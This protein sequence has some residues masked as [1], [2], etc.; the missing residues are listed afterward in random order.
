MTEQRVDME[1]VSFDPPAGSSFSAFD[2]A[3][4]GDGPAVAPALWG[5]FYG[6]AVNTLAGEPGLGKSWIAVA[7]SLH[8]LRRGGSVIVLDYEDSARTWAQRL[9]SLGAEQEQLMDL[10][11]FRGAGAPAEADLDWLPRLAGAAPDVLVVIDSL[12]EALAAA[13]LDENLAGDV[14]SWHQRIARPLADA[15]ATVLLIDHLAKD[16]S[17]RGRWARGSGAKLAAITGAAFR[18]EITEPFSRER[19]GLGQLV[20]SK[21]RYG[22]VGAVGETVANI[23][24][25]VAGGS[26]VRVEVIPLTP[27]AH[28]D[29]QSAPTYLPR[30]AA[31]E[32][33]L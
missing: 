10:L 27:H 33:L 22:A 31:T 12:A 19:S 8:V 13:G 9:R 32:A 18:L 28:G 5:L 17:S 30:P 7:A 3:T 6:A 20:I 14:T 26:L 24:F 2:L 25:D 29:P 16:S 21:D 1:P 15:G 11:Y 4:I 23:R